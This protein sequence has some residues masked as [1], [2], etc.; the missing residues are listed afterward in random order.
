MPQSQGK[1]SAL[2]PSSIFRRGRIAVGPR[3]MYKSRLL[4]R[5]LDLILL[6]STGYNRCA[7]A[8]SAA[9]TRRSQRRL[10]K[11]ISGKDYSQKGDRHIRE[12]T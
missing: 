9:T 3:G 8:Q 7:V 11:Q 4:R 12:Y 5:R 6:T 1:R 2:N 10:V